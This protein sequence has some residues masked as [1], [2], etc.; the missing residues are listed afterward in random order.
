[1]LYK[2]DV[3]NRRGQV[4]TLNME[5]DDGGYQ[6]A[7]IEGLEPV[8]AVM[9]STSFAGVDGEQFQSAKRT[10]RNIVIKLDLDP[11]FDTDTYTTLRKKLYG[12]F[13]PKSEV[14]MRF[15]MTTG[16]NVDIK[17]RVE[18]ISP[19]MF[20]KE[21]TIDVSVMCFEPDFIDPRMVTL[22]GNTV[23]DSTNTFINYPGSVE[24]GVVLTLNPARAVDAF[25]M[26]NMDE[27]GVLYQMDFSGDLLAGD[28]LVVSSLSGAKGITLTRAGVSS[29][30]LYGRSAQSG[31]IELSEG[32][33]EF[34]VYATG[35]PIPYE[36][37]YVVRYGGV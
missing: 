3:T 36:L 26:Y 4:L 6:I 23:A 7:D 28:Q 37:E 8:K 17:G 14:S 2:I 20:N 29:S 19:G 9:V 11:D 35:D 22:S 33:N 24:T 30:Y 5:E 34:R 10:A 27:A 21:P 25:S 32:V 16:L 12:Y 15:Y 31:W 13:M 18:E 1:M